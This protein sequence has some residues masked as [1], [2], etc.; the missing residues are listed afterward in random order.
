M[1]AWNATPARDAIARGSL[2][3]SFAYTCTA[4]PRTH[5]FTRVT[6]GPRTYDGQWGGAGVATALPGWRTTRQHVYTRLFTCIRTRWIR[7]FTSRVAVTFRLGTVIAES[8]LENRLEASDRGKLC[9][10]GDGRVTGARASARSIEWRQQRECVH[11]GAA[12]I[13]HPLF[14]VWFCCNIAHMFVPD[15]RGSCVINGPMHLNRASF[16]FFLF[17]SLF[18]PGLFLF[19]SAEIVVVFTRV[20]NTRYRGGRALNFI[21]EIVFHLSLRF[22]GAL[23]NASYT[24]GEV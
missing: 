5:V 11:F 17:Y 1:I 8:R 10:E 9:K 19:F 15:C 16:F 12:D 24:L 6:R 20:E 4:C 23:A 21:R 14:F 22:V 3:S 13:D 7:V 18:F 2:H